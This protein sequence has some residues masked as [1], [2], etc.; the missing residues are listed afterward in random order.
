MLGNRTING[1]EIEDNQC[2]KTFLVQLP[3]PEDGDSVN[4]TAVGGR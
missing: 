1:H 2:A 3:E 4:V